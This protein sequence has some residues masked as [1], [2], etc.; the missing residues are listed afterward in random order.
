MAKEAISELAAISLVRGPADI[1]PA[2]PDYV[3]A[4]LQHVWS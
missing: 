4:F 3:R 2:M 1:I